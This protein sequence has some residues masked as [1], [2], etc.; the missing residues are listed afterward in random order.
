MPGERI[1][2][3]MLASLSRVDQ[4]RIRTG[5]LDDE[6]WARI[7][8]TMGKILLEKHNN[9]ILTSSGTRR[10]KSVRARGVF[11]AGFMAG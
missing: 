4:A 6:D 5:Q 11:S 2:M 10:Q 1:M 3:R 9:I 7:S 8:G